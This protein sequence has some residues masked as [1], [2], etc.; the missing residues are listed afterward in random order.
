MA[1]VFISY[2]H[3][4][5][6]Q[7]IA[8]RFH[9]DLA[10]A[11]HPTFMAAATLEWG[12]DWPSEITHALDDADYFV[13]MLSKDALL[14]DMV[15]GEVRRAR[16]LRESRGRPVLLPLR[17]NLPFD[18]PI[19][20]ELDSYLHR[21]QQFEWRSP[22]DTEPLSRRL[23]TLIAAGKP[24]S[25]V[26]DDEPPARFVDPGCPPLPS[27]PLELPGGQ[28]S[29]D[30]AFYVT[31]PADRACRDL[32]GK[33]GALVRIKAPRQFGKTS[34]LSRMVAGVRAEGCAVVSLSLQQFD[35]ETIQDVDKLLR[36]VCVYASRRLSLAN[37]TDRYWDDWLDRKER[38]RTYFEEYLLPATPKGLLLAIDEA[39][40]LFEWPDTSTEFFGMLRSWHE[41][42]KVSDVWKR[43]RLALVHSTEVFLAIRDPNQSPFNVGFNAQ[44]GGFSESAIAQLAEAHGLT[45]NGNAA[46][47]LERAVGG[48]PY[49]VRKAL[50]I[51]STEGLSP[52]TFLAT[53]AREDGPFSDHLRRHLW[54][55]TRHAELA[56]AMRRVLRGQ[57]C[58]DPFLCYRLQAA[59]LVR[60]VPPT[61]EMTSEV[62]RTYFGAHL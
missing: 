62:Y 34:L 51:M 12:D 58:H 1:N 28:V 24:Q 6:S 57:P 55:L 35:G 2:S 50:Y 43:F 33:P 45:W 7:D 5:E 4:G 15:A 39:D 3:K 16:H 26:T 40:R 38:C 10:S 48:H 17:V 25:F 47:K 14:S 52:D 18:E 30:S 8:K 46:A 42:S 21:I 37:A 44:L 11:G 36:Q 13:L 53:A 22:N 32:I 9:Q 31:R 20:Y 59:G 27:A 23:L 49:L 56:D 61:V 60:G 41:E 54:N 29:L 19:G